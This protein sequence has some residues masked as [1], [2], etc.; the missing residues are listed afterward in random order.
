MISNRRGHHHRD[1]DR[2]RELQG[3]ALPPPVPGGR[4]EAVE[5]VGEID[6]V[7][8]AGLELGGRLRPVG[9]VLRERR[10]FVH[11]DVVG[12]GTVLPGHEEVDAE[13]E[14]AGEVGDAA[15][16]ADPVH[17]D[18]SQGGLDEVGVF[19]VAL[20]VECQPHQ[21][22]G[23]AGGVDGDDVEEDPDRAEPEVG[24][25]ELAAPQFG[26]EE[27]WQQPV[28]H[29]EDQ[30]TDPAEGAGVDVGDGPVGVV[31]QRLTALIDSSGPSKVD[32]P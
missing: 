8:T 22:L 14:R 5:L 29:A 24:L 9:V 21:T 17:R 26:L 18:Q 19:E 10:R 3:Q 23:E 12:R 1:Q 2:D 31:G 6:D 20:G 25:G 27:A 7:G 4:E 11:R 15:D 13:Q 32:M 28:D 16:D 30:E